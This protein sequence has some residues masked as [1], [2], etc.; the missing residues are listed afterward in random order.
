M[1][2]FTA[3]RKVAAMAEAHYLDI[4]PHTPQGTICLA[5]SVHLCAAVHNFAVLEYNWQ[6]PHLPRDLF[7]KQLELRGDGFPLPQGPG[8]GIEFDE[9]AARRYPPL[10]WEAPHFRRRDGAFTNY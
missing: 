9:E 10:S 6:M 4:V 2:G 7:P 8:L 1:G 3:S 5:A